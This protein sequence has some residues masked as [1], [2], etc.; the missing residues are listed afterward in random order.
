MDI[1][2]VTGLVLVGLMILLVLSCILL[3]GRITKAV[4]RIKGEDSE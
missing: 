1:F 3:A 4:R 2:W